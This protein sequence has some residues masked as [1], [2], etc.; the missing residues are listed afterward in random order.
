MIMGKH[1]FSEMLDKSISIQYSM[2]F[3][4]YKSW[5][6]QEFRSHISDT[7]NWEQLYTRKF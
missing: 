3:Y 5:E 4:I 6:E 7:T 2:M 1:T